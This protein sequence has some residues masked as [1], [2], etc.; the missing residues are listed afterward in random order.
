V[1]TV[2][3]PTAARAALL[4]LA[5]QSIADQTALGRITRIFVSENGGDRTSERICAEFPQLPITYVFREPAVTPLEHAQ[6]MMKEFPQGDVTFI[7]HDDDWWLP[8]HVENAL[9][10]LDANPD[11]SL[12]GANYAVY[13]G[14][15]ISDEQSELPAW[16]GANYPMPAPLWKLSSSNALLA[17]IYGPVVHY[18]CMAIR[19]EAL[20]AS[21]YVYDLGNAFDN[22]RMIF[23]AL[24]RQGPVFFGSEFSVGI[25]V[26]PVRDTERFAPEVRISRYAE[27]TAWMVELSG[28][29][30]SL[31]ASS[32]LQR[33]ANCPHQKTKDFLFWQA[34]IRDW[35]L[36]EMAR[37]L[38]RNLDEE[39]F[40]LY[41]KGSTTFAGQTVTFDR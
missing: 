30:W 36:P 31:V 33:I 23:Y 41:D 19:T 11:A 21:T 28:K 18:S 27:T 12:Y 37:H 8:R 2:I 6:L 29:P 9:A 10:V 35:C 32:F 38:D 25:R 15:K 3:L 39:F 40:A 16:F 1:V 17:S 14:T 7:L 34:T 24:S 13:Q 20:R 22:D 5:L 4:P 26:H